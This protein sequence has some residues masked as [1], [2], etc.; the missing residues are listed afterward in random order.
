[1]DTDS[2]NKIYFSLAFVFSLMILLYYPLGLVRAISY[3]NPI[4]NWSELEGFTWEIAGFFALGMILLKT[5]AL[6]DFL[7]KNKIIAVGSAFFIL[8]LILQQIFIFP[9]FYNFGGGLSY[10]ALIGAGFL[11]G[12]EF[13][14]VFLPLFWILLL[15]SL[16]MDLHDVFTPH[17]SGLTGNWNWSATL[18][19]VLSWSIF[20]IFRKKIPEFE[21]RWGIY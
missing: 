2:K 10:L 5:S 21:S 3:K 7:K 20:F 4:S 6:I 8:I 1:M 9:S 17:A 13:K 12:R 15:F 11:Y 18:I 16:L 19:L 14:K